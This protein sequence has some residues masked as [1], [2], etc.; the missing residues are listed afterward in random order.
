MGGYNVKGLQQTE[1]KQGR[2]IL[3]SEYVQFVEGG[4]TTY[5][6]LGPIEAGQALARYKEYGAYDGYWGRYSDNDQARGI[7]DAY[8]ILNTSTEV[9][10]TDNVVLGEVIVAGSVY[11]SRIVTEQGGV[12]ETF[13]SLTP[14]IRYVK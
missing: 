3:A 2:N 5:S 10:G 9:W 13:K 8:G 1:F 14:M 6:G 12:T 7:Y 4:A 11:E